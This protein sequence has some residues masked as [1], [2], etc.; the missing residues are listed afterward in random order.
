MKLDSW[1]PIEATDRRLSFS[2]LIIRITFG[3]AMAIHG[4]PKF[5]NMTTW[6]GP[7]AP[8]PTIL[9]ALAAIAE[10]LGGIAIALGALTPIAA[11]GNACTML[12]AATFHI[13]K[14]D[15]WISKGGEGS[16]E[17][18]GIYFV[19]SVAILLIGPGRYSIDSM[20]QWKYRAR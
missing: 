1:Y 18:A 3:V 17:L 13:G 16:W 10:F 5:Q 19:L 11:F 6:M 7:D 2:L 9:I 15:P 14:G 4:W 12:V 20:L 8:V